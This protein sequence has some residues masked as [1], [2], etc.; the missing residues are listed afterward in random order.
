M[1]NCASGIST[2]PPRGG[3]ADIA[4][5]TERGTITTQPPIHTPRTPMSV[6]PPLVPRVDRLPLGD[7]L[8]ERSERF[9]QDLIA[10]LPGFTNCHLY[11]TRGQKQHG[12]DLF[13]DDMAGQRWAFSNKRYQEYHP[14]NARDHIAE[15][16]YPA[17]RYVILL[18]R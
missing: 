8:W 5:H 6:P 1:R 13:A 3:L 18:S 9:A 2:S 15:T 12:I 17:G 11:G 7:M 14:S 16:T 10:R 4:P